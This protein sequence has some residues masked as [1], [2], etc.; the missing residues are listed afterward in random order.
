MIVTRKYITEL[1]TE[2]KR[3]ARVFGLDE[4]RRVYNNLILL[5]ING[6]K[7]GI[8]TI[9]PVAAVKMLCEQDNL[10]VKE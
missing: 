1:L 6:H 5:H 8:R 9:N 10:E 7:K 3:Y 2:R 4:S